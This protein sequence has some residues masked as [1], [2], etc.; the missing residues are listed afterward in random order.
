MAPA[1]MRTAASSLSGAKPVPFWLDDPERPDARPALTGDEHTDLLVVGGGYSGLWTALI[2]KERDPDRDVVLIEGHEVGWAASGRNGGF[3]AASLTHGLANGV[4]RWPDEIAKLEE[5]GER[6][7]DAIEA[8][9][10]RYGIDCEFER[11]GEIDVAT[12]PHQLQELRE[13]H[14][15]IVKLGI[16]GVDFLDRD[17]LRAEVDSPTFL[18]GLWDRRGVA[19]L[20]PAK[21]AWGLKRACREL[22]VR[23]YEHTRGLELAR[24]GEG[25]AVRTPYGRVFARRVALGTNIFP[26]LVKRVRP[27]TVPVY[28]YALMTEPLTPAQLESIGWKGRQGLGDSANQFH[29]FRLSAD[30]RILWGGYDAI[31]PYGGKLN[32]DLDQRPETFLKLAEQFFTCFPQLSGVRFS[33][34]WGGAIDT[35]SRFT[36]FFGTAHQGRVAY[37]AGYTGL[38]VGST[39]FGADVMLDLLSGEETERTRL[40]MVRSKPMPFPPEPFAWAGIEITRRSLAHADDNGG[41]RNLWLKTMDKLGLGFDS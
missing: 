34:A 32:A 13:W 11:T 37:A 1:A 18:G 8:A 29:Y 2:A 31:Y 15:E 22:G 30:N 12:E 20:H 17:A 35:C 39:R 16:T 3:C 10:A 14:E 7:L 28:D 40:E 5:L 23:I 9:V 27:Y 33:H 24:S 41:R 4:E 19:M 25:M 6:N 21:L 38:G 36:A 26:S